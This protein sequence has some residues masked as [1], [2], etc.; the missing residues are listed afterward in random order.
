MTWITPLDCLT[1][2]IVTV[3]VPSVS[4]CS[5]ILSPFIMAT[6]VPPETVLIVCLPPSCESERALA[7]KAT[8]RL[9]QL[10]AGGLDL[11]LIPCACRPGTEGTRQCNY[12]RACGVLTAGWEGR[13]C[14][15]DIRGACT[16]VRLRPDVV[17]EARALVSLISVQIIRCVDG[18]IR[19]HLRSGVPG[20]PKPE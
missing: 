1:L 20:K 6:R 9:R 8:F 18:S 19:G 16:T 7:A 13:G 11:E 10:S 2:A 5:T 14:N 3:A 4:S 15:S 17:S 12:G